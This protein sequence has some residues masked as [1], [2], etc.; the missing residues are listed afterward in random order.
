MTLKNLEDYGN[1]FQIKVI[2][3]LLTY[4]DF[5]V[6]IS[7][8]LDKEQFGNQAHQWIIEEILKYY[9]K[10]HTTPTMEVLKVELQ[11]LKNE[12][13][14]ISIKEQLKLAYKASQ[15]DLVY[16]QTEFSTFCKDQQLKKALLNSVDLLE[17]GD[18][19]SIR[20][21]VVDA[22][23]SGEDRNIGHEYEKDIESRYRED[24]R[25][26]I[27]F[28]WE[29]FNQITQG[30]YG[31]GDLV[32]IFGSPKGGKSWTVMAMA[33]F[34]VM[35][36]Y[37][38]VFYSLELGESY[39]A[40]RFDAIFTGIP[41]EDLDDH[42]D[43]VEEAISKLK[44]R[45]V[46]KGY[47]PKRASLATIE[48][49]LERLD[50]KPKAVFIDYLDL[51]R[52]SKNRTERKDDIDDVYTEAKGMAKDRN[53]PIISPSQANRSGAEKS[54]LESTHIAGSYDKIMIG[55]IVISQARGRKDKLEGTARFHIMGN[56]Y[57]PDGQT[58]L[59]PTVDTSIGKIEIDERELD[60]NEIHLNSNINQKEIESLEKS[61]LREKFEKW[62][63][64]M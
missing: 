38:I 19:N 4:K 52:N 11:K 27:P 33:A 10:Y 59:A 47:S 53:I 51:L 25:N 8:V 23:K 49:H 45:L 29:I 7:D 34:A 58:Y 35:L 5:L 16:V 42:R 18:Y 6:N 15:E 62:E 28:P 20:K 13:L 3:S 63:N 61:K 50:F 46:I 54:I 36:G 41:V 57:G 32:L 43:K 9:K 26:P 12:I 48:S 31:E 24:L 22:I 60:E 2:S 56:R 37:D 44:G 40:K 55:D 21:L 14:Q 39:V 64:R 1:S 30:G 17:A